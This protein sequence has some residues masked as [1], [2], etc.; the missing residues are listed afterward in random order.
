MFVTVRNA[1]NEH[2][3]DL[4]IETRKRYLV[5]AYCNECHVLNECQEWTD[6]IHAVFSGIFNQKS[7]SP[8][9]VIHKI[10]CAHAACM[11]ATKRFNRA[12]V[13]LGITPGNQANSSGDPQTISVW[14]PPELLWYKVNVD[15]SWN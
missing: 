7:V 3:I 12:A 1:L 2:L 11:E 4:M 15:A 13:G 9:Q 14:S 10:N 8:L 6:M 5:Y